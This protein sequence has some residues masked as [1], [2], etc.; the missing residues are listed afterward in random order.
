M[1]KSKPKDPKPFV[2]VR[3]APDWSVLGMVTVMARTSA[4]ARRLAKAE[5]AK[6]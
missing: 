5:F 4:E 6:A 3:R 2:V 1:Y